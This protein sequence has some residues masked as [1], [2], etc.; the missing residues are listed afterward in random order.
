MPGS[1]WR[2][3]AGQLLLAPPN[4]QLRSKTDGRWAV[5]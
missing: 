2:I 1:L 4:S 5:R 3:L